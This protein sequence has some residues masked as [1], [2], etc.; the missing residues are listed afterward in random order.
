MLYFAYGANLNKAGMERRCPNAVPVG[1]F[2]MPNHQLVFKGVADIEEQEG[3]FVEGVL[4]DITD[5]CEK[6]L[7]RFEGYPYLYI[8]KLHWKQCNGFA[9]PVM[10]YVMKKSELS[11]PSQGYVDCIREGYEDFNLDQRCLDYALNYTK[12]NDSGLKH[13]SVQWG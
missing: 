9:E 4:W 8:K 10:F 13:Y 12:K 2:I 5:E 1:K 3:S 11:F 6:A 7:D